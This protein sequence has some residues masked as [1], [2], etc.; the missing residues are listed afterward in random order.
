MQSAKSAWL[1]SFFFL[2]S[3]AISSSKPA[4][5]HS[6]GFR[7][8]PGVTGAVLLPC[9]GSYDVTCMAVYLLWTQRCGQAEDRVLCPEETEWDNLSWES[10]RLRLICVFSVCV[11][12]VRIIFVPFVMRMTNF[13]LMRQ[14]FPGFLCIMIVIT[15]CGPYLS[16]TGAWMFSSSMRSL[17]TSSHLPLI[18]SMARSSFGVH[19]NKSMTTQ[20]ASSTIFS[21]YFKLICILFHRKCQN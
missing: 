16:Y 17:M 20:S 11:L 6:G 18:F 2:S 1:C 10:K 19:Y 21:S 7:L 5:L 12:G 9:R 13:I 15:S 14:I 3:F 8:V 4:A